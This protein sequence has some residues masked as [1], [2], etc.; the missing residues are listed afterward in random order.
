MP[1]AWGEGGGGGWDKFGLNDKRQKKN[2][3]VAI[4]PKWCEL[5]MQLL[6]YTNRK[7]Y[8]GNPTAPLNL[9]LGDLERLNSRSPRFCSL[10]FRKGTILGHY[11]TIKHQ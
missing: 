1:W 5:D 4:T 2:F 3:Q 8:I 11:V 6:L 9:T 7:S 10:I